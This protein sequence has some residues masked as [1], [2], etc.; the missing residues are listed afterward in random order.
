MTT[1]ARMTSERLEQ[2]KRI[3][4]SFN[5]VTARAARDLLSELAAATRERDE[6]QREAKEA[7]NLLNHSGCY[8]LSSNPDVAHAEQMAYAQARAANE[9]ARG[10]KEGTKS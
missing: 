5:S 3:A 10:M 7:R 4:G 8:I 1:P 6:A 2:I 9:A